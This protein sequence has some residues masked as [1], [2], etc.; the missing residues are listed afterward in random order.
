MLKFLEMSVLTFWLL[1]LASI[2]DDL[3]FVAKKQILRIIKSIFFSQENVEIRRNGRNVSFDKIFLAQRWR[4]LQLLS[5]KTKREAE[6]CLLAVL[7]TAA[8]A[9]D[10]NERRE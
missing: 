4:S 2:Q 3:N 7:H 1:F 5:L 8:A 9:D 6:F 10:N